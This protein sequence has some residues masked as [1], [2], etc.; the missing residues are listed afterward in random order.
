[1]LIPLQPDD[2][3]ITVGPD[4]IAGTGD[5]AADPGLQ[6]MVLT[7]ATNLAGPDGL[8]GTSDDMHEDTNT[9]TPFVDQN[10]TYSSHPSHQVFLRDY[11]IG[12]DGLLHSTGAL[13]STTGRA[14]GALS[15]DDDTV[16]GQATWLD[17]RLN[18]L[19]LGIL[20]T[21]T[22]V[23]DVPLLA[24]DAYGNVMLTTAR[25]SRPLRPWAHRQWCATATS[26]RNE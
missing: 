22:D 3:L 10:Q 16:S 17:L 24:T 7:R 8:I 4:G 26:S 25:A 15:T 13:L 9:T 5:E 23:G 11:I 21:D 14:D 20:L 2:P 1:M 18:A 6:F 19:K 12:A